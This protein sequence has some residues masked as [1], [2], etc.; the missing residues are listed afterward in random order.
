[1]WHRLLEIGGK[2]YLESFEGSK[3]VGLKEVP[4]S[5]KE[6]KKMLPDEN[7][8]VFRGDATESK[9]ETP[10]LKT[11]IDGFFEAL[12]SSTLFS[13]GQKVAICAQALLESSKGTSKLA[14]EANNFCGM[15][16]RSEF[17][18]HSEFS[19]IE[20]TSPS[21]NIKTDY[22]K[23]ATPQDFLK[24]YFIFIQRARYKGWN[25]KKESFDYILHLSECGY[26]TD[27]LY[28]D[29]V[30]SL[31][32][33][34]SK[35]MGLEKNVNDDLG[36]IKIILDPGHSAKHVGATGGAP[37]FP[38]E[39]VFTLYIAEKLKSKLVSAGA[40][41]NINNP[42]GD[43]LSAIGQTA[44]GNDLFLSIHLNATN[45]YDYYTCVM[46]NKSFHKSGSRAFASLLANK[47]AVL[48]NH[49][50]NS[51]NPDGVYDTANLSVL[52]SA[53]K[54]DCPICVLSE[55]F[56]ID[57]YGLNSAVKERCDKVIDA[58]YSAIVEQ[59][60]G[61]TPKKDIEKPVAKDGFYIL[62]NTNVKLSENFTSGEFMC[63]CGTCGN[64]KISVKLIETLQKIR[65][66]FGGSVNVTS[67]FRCPSHNA[68]V[69]GVYNSEHTKGIASDFWIDNV[70]PLQIKNYLEGAGFIGG[71]GTYPTFTHVDVGA[72]GRW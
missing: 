37:D 49:K 2:N 26:A 7:I 67:G 54:T 62:S 10:V 51:G 42:I 70:T 58:M 13:P 60:S 25:E 63:K 14:V 44:K 34:A 56:F 69:G 65:N 19:K 39:E 71:I 41:V 66:T 57:A 59:F 4:F 55:S 24:A 48:L 15:M 45:G 31:F 33:E 11:G 32:D 53:E 8:C 27:L 1:M 36:G 72:N 20:Y 22:L 30:A 6:L 46:I 21:D 9:E 61:K 35:I 38:K 18:S 12:K 17:D 52:S 28:V 68:T 43:E 29:K 3:S 50:K 47:Q 5:G 16:Y 64:N 40:I 23:C